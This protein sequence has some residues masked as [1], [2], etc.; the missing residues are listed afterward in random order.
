MM[1]AL[2]E[3]AT[4]AEITLL[5]VTTNIR[6]LNPAGSARWHGYMGRPDAVAHALGQRSN[7]VTVAFGLRYR[8]C[9][10]T[11]HTRSSRPIQQ[12]RPENTNDGIASTRLQR[13]VSSSEW[14]PAFEAPQGLQQAH[15]IM[16]TA[17][18]LRRFRKCIRTMLRVARC[19][20]LGKDRPSPSGILR[21]N[22]VLD[23]AYVSTS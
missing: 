15:R 7:N 13:P 9:A 14:P 16:A 12:S 5:P 1:E 11:V 22:F 8:T 10:R 3:L 19:G 18:E 21:L 4:E 23:K 17:A 6:S 20:M 2:A